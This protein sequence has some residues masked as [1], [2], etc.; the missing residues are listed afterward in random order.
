MTQHDMQNPLTQYPT[1]DIPEQTQPEPGL[2]AKLKPQ[3]D[4]GFD[5]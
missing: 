1:M 2:D 4:H 5:T 3:A